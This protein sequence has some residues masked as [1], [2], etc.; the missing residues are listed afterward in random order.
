MSF[1]IGTTIGSYKIVEKLG[2]G[3]M[4]TVYKGRHTRLKRDVAIKVLHPMLNDD[5]SFLR[6]FAR[7]AQ[8]VAKLEH[9]HIVPVYDF[10]EHEGQPYLVM[11]LVEGDTLKDRMTKGTLS[12][13]EI[14]R[15]AQAVADGLDYAHRQ[16]VLHRDIKPSN[17]MLTSA[18]GVYIADFGLARMAQAGESTLSQDMI[19]GTPQYI[20]PEQAMGNKDLDGRTDLY[21]FAIILY[22][23]VTGQTPFQSETTYSIIHMQIFDP[24]PPPSEVN[25]NISPE[26]EAVLLKALSK[27]PQERYA[28]GRELVAAYRD[29]FNGMPEDFAP[30]GAT[31]LPEY[32]PAGMTRVQSEPTETSEEDIAVEAE[33]EPET[34]PPLP[35]LVTVDETPEPVETEQV[36]DE[37][38][39]TAVPPVKKKRSKWV[40]V[41]VVAVL[42]LLCCALSF[43]A[44]TFIEEWR[45][46]EPVAGAPRPSDGQPIENPPPRDEDENILEQPSE[47]EEAP[48]EE[49]ESDTPGRPLILQ[50]PR[51]IRPIEE[52][53]AELRENPDDM[54]LKVELAAAFMRE[55]NPEEARAILGDVFS[56][57]RQPHQVITTIDRLMETENYEFAALM[58]YG[59]LD[60]FREDP[61]LQHRLLMAL[62][63]SEA[64]P[65]RIEEYVN[66]VYDLDAPHSDIN[67][68]MADAYLAFIDGEPEEALGI[69]EELTHEE[70]PFMAST[71]FFIGKLHK[72]MR[73]P[74]AAREA[75]E[76]AIDHEPFPWLMMQIERE[77]Y[78]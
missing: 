3:G 15:I 22:E 49:P 59:A 61:E 62:I 47:P 66:F 34:I 27:E 20:S 45:D 7:E 71:F 43:A 2:R 74:E 26:M 48:L 30:S 64:P 9:P 54:Q 42:L 37:A 77:L 55:G 35:E 24:P 76:Q 60:R 6:R 16:G 65:E 39:E 11:R 41:G 21:S 58:L 19:M 72:E 32:T 68:E 46:D 53:D 23:L 44:A 29:A 4:A 1:K 31:V 14:L 18:N 12:R 69:L 28:T 33:P 25:E 75:F 63:L 5:D 13:D 38:E 17:V 52:I 67:L 10:A 36:E 73:Q 78:P 56:R 57:F 8:L 70:N 51:E 50:P 40:I